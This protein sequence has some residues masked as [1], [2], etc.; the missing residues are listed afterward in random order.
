MIKYKL[1]DIDVSKVL[2]ISRILTLVK[3]N[4]VNF[5]AFPDIFVDGLLEFYSI[6]RILSKTYSDIVEMI[7]VTKCITEGPKESIPHYVAFAQ[8]NS[9]FDEEG[10]SMG[11]IAHYFLSF[12]GSFEERS[13]ACEKMFGKWCYGGLKLQFSKAIT[14]WRRVVEGVK[15]LG[16][17]NLVDKA[18]VDCFMEAE[19]FFKSKR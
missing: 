1:I 13:S 2:L 3:A 9:L 17:H 19:D 8:T 18:V 14:F 10:V 7:L 16:N 4:S 11:I 12:E 15:Q 6:S 5:V